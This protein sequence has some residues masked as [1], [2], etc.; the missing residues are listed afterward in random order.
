M[1]NRP[2][3][4]RTDC[5]F[6]NS[7]L[8]LD[9][10]LRKNEAIGNARPVQHEETLSEADMKRLKEWFEDALTSDCA[11]KLQSFTWYVLARHLALRGGEV[12]SK[13]TRNDLEFTEEDSIEFVKLKTDFLTKNTPGWLSDAREFRCCGRVQEPKQVEALKRL[14]V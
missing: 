4:I 7:N 5:E 6:Q 1:L 12:F 3:N 8:V 13:L 14:F 2:F 9:A 11:Y 10:V